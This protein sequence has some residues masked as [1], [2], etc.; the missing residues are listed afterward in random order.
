M[1]DTYAYRSDIIRWIFAI[2]TLGLV[3]QSARLQLFDDTYQ[4][5]AQRTTINKK[6][7]EPARGIFIIEQG[8]F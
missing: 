7:I 6:V 1:K 4:K 8:R 5:I 2:S 3:I